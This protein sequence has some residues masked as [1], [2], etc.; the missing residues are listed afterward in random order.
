MFPWL[1]EFKDAPCEITDN[2]I[3]KKDENYDPI[4]DELLRIIGRIQTTMRNVDL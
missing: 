3:I 1:H 4:N 2:L